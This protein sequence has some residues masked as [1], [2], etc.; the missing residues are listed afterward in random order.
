[1]DA[2]GEFRLGQRLQAQAADTPASAALTAPNRKPVG[3]G[4]LYRHIRSAHAVLRDHDI[5]RRD[6]IAV[7]LPEGPGFAAAILAVSSSAVAAPL[8]PDLPPAELRYLLQRMQAKAIV[9]ADDAPPRLLEAA[10]DTE[11]TILTASVLKEGHIGEG[12]PQ[13]PA[14]DD[15]AVLLFTSGTTARPKA[16]ALSNRNVCLSA[17]SMATTLSLGGD[18]AG[19]CVMPLFHVHGLVGTVLAP[20]LSGGSVILPGRFHAA[21]FFEQFEESRP[22]WFSAT[23]AILHQ[24][25]ERAEDQEAI[26]KG[27]RLRFIRS[28]SAPL[29]ATLM[30]KLEHRFQVP[31]IEAFGMT[32]ASHQIASN[33]L[34]PASRKP[35]SVGV[36]DTVQITI[37]GTRGEELPAGTSGEI[38]LRGPTVISG[39]LDDEAADGDAF[40]DGWLRTGD[41]GYLDADGY[42]H[43]DGRLKEIINRGGENVAPLEVE[44]VLNA[45]PAVAESAVFAVPDARLGEEIA[46]AVVRRDGQESTTRE[47]QDFA[48]SRLADFKV[49][50][51]ILFVG[52]LPKSETGKL[53]RNALQAQ[54]QERGGVDED[55]V[56]SGQAAPSGETVQRIAAIWSEVLAVDAI[57][58]DDNFFDIGGDSLQATMIIARIQES[59]GVELSMAALFDRPTIGRLAAEVETAIQAGKRAFAA[60]EPIDAASKDHPL[61]FTQQ[62]ILDVSSDPLLGNATVFNRIAVLHVT[63]PLDEKALRGALDGIVAR[64]AI[65]RAGVSLEGTDSRVVVRP[66]EAVDLTG[67]ELGD[68]GTA[69]QDRRLRAAMLEFGRRPYDL[70]RDPLVRFGLVRLGEEEHRLLVCAHNL[71]FDG[72][73]M[74]LF[75]DEL[76]QSY[77]AAR[78]GGIAAPEAPAIQYSDYARWQHKS[79]EAGALDARLTYWRQLLAPEPPPVS[80]N[81]NAWTGPDNRFELDRHVL[82]LDADLVRALRTI[83]ARNGATLNM[84]LLTALAVLFAKLTGHEDVLFL[85]QSAGRAQKETESLIGN[86]V[87]TLPVRAHV[88]AGTPFSQQL[89]AMRRGCLD[90][91]ANEDVPFSMLIDELFPD[92]N[93]ML[94][95]VSPLLFVFKNF[96]MPE[97]SADDVTFTPVDLDFAS[98]VFGLIVKVHEGEGALPCNFLFNRCAVSEGQVRRLA[99]CYRV[100][101]DQIARDPSV[102]VYKCLPAGKLITALGPGGI[103]AAFVDSL[104]SKLSGV[105]RAPDS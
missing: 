96:S 70:A 88:R 98:E 58:I 77:A 3:Y 91:T 86:F 40:R 62:L 34:P 84:V 50:R 89:D 22:T 53:R 32:E 24:I 27:S 37:H 20:L 99:A 10:R 16:V 8:N 39:Y 73:S 92:R 48:A 13:W 29:P 17:L 15:R 101:L 72:W 26:I 97:A 82:P 51:H 28:A 56:A 79:L 105:H 2:D 9:V 71:V 12:D 57:G 76:A 44:A 46:A 69:D 75:I 21:R 45:H 19:L 14:P 23:P 7:A 55:A 104:R 67:I 6:A 81:R 31:V 25:A 63:G 74:R 90:A 102:P 11:A 68:M 35:G 103:I 78:R 18:D 42:L 36:A 83:A 65:L 4:D 52:E 61:S 59:L 54:W 93:L 30:E 60:I 66:P 49:P 41:R 5:D 94:N 100:V 33:P 43:I 64:H 95:P 87:Q 80:F 85:T 1:M 47:L 38:L